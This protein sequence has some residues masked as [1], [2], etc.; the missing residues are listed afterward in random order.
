V[1]TLEQIAWLKKTHE[2]AGGSAG[3]S[4][5]TPLAG[6][7]SGDLSETRLAFGGGPTMSAAPAAGS[8]ITDLRDAATAAPPPGPVAPAPPAGGTADPAAPAEAQITATY[9]ARFTPAGQPAGHQF[10]GAKPVPQA[11]KWEPNEVDTVDRAF[12]AIAREDKGIL[13]D[14]SLSRVTSLSGGGD[15]LAEFQD[16][17]DSQSGTATRTI[18]VTDGNFS[19]NRG[20]PLSNDEPARS[21][22]HE[23]GHALAHR[24]LDQAELAD[25]KAFQAIN[26]AQ[27]KFDKAKADH[28]DWKQKLKAKLN[29]K[30][31]P[32]DEYERVSQLP[33][34]DKERA[35]LPQL[36]VESD[37]LDKDEDPYAKAQQAAGDKLGDAQDAQMLTA[38]AVEDTKVPKE[39]VDAG[40]AR[41]DSSA[42]LADGEST[43][44][45]PDISKMS[46]EQL[47]SSKDYRTTSSSVTSFLKTYSDMIR[48]GKVG[49]RQDQKSPDDW[50]KDVAF[51]F[52]G[53][54]NNRKELESRDR[55][56]PALKI[57]APV[58]R[59]A[60]TWR[61]EAQTQAR[62]P[63]RLPKV[64]KFVDMVNQAPAIDP[65]TVSPYAAQSWPHKPEEFFA[66]CYSLWRMN[67]EQKP[68]MKPKPLPPRIFKWFD[69]GSYR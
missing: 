11:K 44:L 36:R 63:R 1:L 42:A 33:K 29:G 50:D 49:P 32:R 35:R 22:V 37:R 8:P 27:K 10:A 48:A 43:R 62:L 21:I 40:Q 18:L 45:E 51:M 2:M 67:P 14:I 5:G 57:L 41:L 59:A 4:G 17:E 24:A 15:T 65:G 26:D 30:P 52:N 39:V 61:K 20:Q 47:K 34:N 6:S 3:Q 58:D 60:D 53:R 66:E 28:D 12:K 31:D 69:E 9:G 38:K 13:Q 46:P 55:N 7:K 64:Q 56:N 19:A 16:A 54:D 25:A 23:V 68:E